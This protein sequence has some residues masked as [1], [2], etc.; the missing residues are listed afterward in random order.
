MVSQREGIEPEPALAHG[1]E[2]PEV[3][4]EKDQQRDNHGE[5]QLDVLLVHLRSKNTT[6]GKI[7]LYFVMKSL[8]HLYFS[9][10][11]T[12]VNAFSPNRAYLAYIP[13][14]YNLEGHNISNPLENRNQN[15][16]DSQICMGTISVLSV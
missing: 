2:D 9:V 4:D 8:V 11:H 13:L 15:L 10:K 5:G 3:E 1:E 16:A 7:N 6:C 14:A 12:K